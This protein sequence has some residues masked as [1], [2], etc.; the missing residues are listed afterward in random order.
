MLHL[1]LNYKYYGILIIIISIIQLRLSM[2]FSGIKKLTKKKHR[3]FLWIV[4]WL[5]IGIFA[6]TFFP[7][8][9]VFILTP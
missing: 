4:V 6:S 9:A 5:L 7:F 8:M 3:V 2:G 1:D